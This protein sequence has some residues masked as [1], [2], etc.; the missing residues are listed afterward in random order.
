[1]SHKSEAMQAS[2]GNH[3]SSASTKWQK[4]NKVVY[5]SS[6]SCCRAAAAAAAAH[7]VCA[8]YIISLKSLMQ[9]Q[10][11]VCTYRYIQARTCVQCVSRLFEIGGEK[12]GY[13][14]ALSAVT[15]SRQAAAAHAYRLLN[16]GSADALEIPGDI[17]THTYHINTAGRLYIGIYYKRQ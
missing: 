14:A 6:L 16:C 7:V 15:L 10:C 13:C 17:N 8:S 9:F 2:R 12:L 5:A 11:C 3:L 1:M 4:P